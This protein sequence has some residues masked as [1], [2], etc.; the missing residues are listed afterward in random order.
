MPE[1]AVGPVLT[2]SLFVEVT[3]TGV[4]SSVVVPTVVSS[5]VGVVSRL[6]LVPLACFCVAVAAVGA[7]ALPAAEIVA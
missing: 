2:T 6:A 1:F 3:L 4:A 5:V 7:E